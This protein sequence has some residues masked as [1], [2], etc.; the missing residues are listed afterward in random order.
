MLQ[1][2]YEIIKKKK[3]FFLKIFNIF[4]FGF[5]LVSLIDVRMESSSVKA[6]QMAPSPSGPTKRNAFF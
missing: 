3:D 5:G 4:S 6:T 1:I 2:P